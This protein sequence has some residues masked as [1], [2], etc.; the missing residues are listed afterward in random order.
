M[1]QPAVGVAFILTNYDNKKYVQP[2]VSEF[3]RFGR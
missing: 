1:R 2:A 3:D